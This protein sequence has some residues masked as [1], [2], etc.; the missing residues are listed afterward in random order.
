RHPEQLPLSYGQQRMWFLNRLATTSED[1]EGAEAAGAGLTG[2]AAGVYNMPLALRLSGHLDT[3]ALEAAL[4]DVADRHESLRT[5]FPET[6]GVP[7][8]RVLD[9]P[10]AHPPLVV[11]DLPADQVEAELSAHAGRGFELGTELPW[12]ARLLV[13][14]PTEYVLL[15]VAHHIAADGWSMGVL[16]R[17]LS[18]AYAARR[19]GRAPVW[20]PLPVRYA[21]FALW[22]RRLLGERGDADSLLSDQLAYW[23]DAL[24]D[25]PQELALPA[26]RPRPA[27]SSYAGG[28]VPVR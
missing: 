19:Q 11:V 5:V 13:T 4:A 8:Q 27:V 3:G 21:D 25:A 24:A 9:G 18:T 15:I 2:A 16:A 14:G 28:L 23:H 26:D 20:E 10:A 12:R 1:A 6:D 7:R 17:D 22:Q